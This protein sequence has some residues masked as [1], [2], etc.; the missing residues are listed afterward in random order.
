MFTLSALKD[1]L[2]GRLKVPDLGV[3]LHGDPRR[4][5]DAEQISPPILCPLKGDTERL[6]H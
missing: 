6:S 4:V 5:N 3:V 2:S 1:G